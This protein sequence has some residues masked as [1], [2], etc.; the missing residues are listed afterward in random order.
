MRW[1]LYHVKRS[2]RHEALRRPIVPR[3]L[4]LTDTFEESAKQ[5]HGMTWYDV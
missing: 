2:A 3:V 4:L 5:M 1:M